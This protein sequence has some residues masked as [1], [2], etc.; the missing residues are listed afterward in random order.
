MGHSSPPCVLETQPETESDGSPLDSVR[1]THCRQLSQRCTLYT[2]EDLEN[3]MSVLVRALTTGKLDV[4]T[5]GRGPT[6]LARPGG[7]LPRIHFIPSVFPPRSL[8]DGTPECNG[9]DRNE[10]TLKG[11]LY[12]STYQTV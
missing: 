7:L 2:A 9:P 1:A 4:W 8:Q 10:N 12:F 3:G 5:A 6:I 11:N